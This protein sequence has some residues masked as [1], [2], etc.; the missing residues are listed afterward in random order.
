MSHR[1]LI[2]DHTINKPSWGQLYG[3]SLSL[4]L[5]E[6][7]LQTPGIKLCITPDNWYAKQLIEDLQFFLKDH[8][9][10]QEILVFPDWETL[11]YDQFSPHQDIISERL[12]ALSRLPQLKT[13]IVISSVST[14]MH[15]IAP[16]DFV[17]QHSLLLECHQQLNLDT[18]R[19]QLIQA[20]YHA[21]NTVLEH[22]EFALRGAILDLFPMGSSI[23]YRI[24]LFD[25]EIASLRSF[26]PES[27]RTIDKIEKIHILPAREMLFNE[28]GIN[29]FRQAFRNEFSGNPSQ[30]P[31]YEAVS[32][33]Q[34]PAGIEYYLPLFFSKAVSF[35]DYLPPEST[36]TMIGSTLDYAEQFWQELNQRFTQR[37][38]DRNRPILAPERC[39][40]SPNE[41]LAATKHYTRIK[42]S[43]EPLTEKKSTHN[44]AVN[45]P[46]LFTIDRHS[47][48]PFH[49]FKTWL[50]TTQQRAI[51]VVESL[52]RRE[53]ILDLLKQSGITPKWQPSW[54]ACIEDNAPI[55]ITLGT[56]SDGAELQHLSI[57]VE[58]QLF[59]QQATPQQRKITKSIDPDV[60]IRDLAE[61]RIGAPVVHLEF[62]VGRYQGLQTFVH[63]GLSNEFLCLSYAGDDKIYVP[64]TSLHLISRYTGADSDHAPLHRLGSD[65]WQKEKKKAAEKIH[66]V[67]IELLEIYAK[68]AQAPGHQ[69][70]LHQLDYQRFAAGFPFTLTNDQESAITQIIQDMQSPHPMDRLICGDVGFGKTEVAMRAAFIAA[71]DGQQICVLCPTTLLADQHFATFR[72]RF[73]DFPITIELLSRFRSEKQAEKVVQGLANG[74]IDIVIGTHKLLQKSIQFKQ[75]GLLI[76]DEEHRFGVKQKEYIKSLRAQIDL[77]CMTAT[78]IPRTLNM[79]MA[80]IRDISL[81]ATPPA[82]RLAIKTFWQEHSDSIV[83]EAILRE[84]LRGG[85][86]FF[87][88]NNVQ[89]I[90]RI[91]QELQKLVPQA[92]V[93][94]AHGQ[95]RERELERIMSDFYH[96]QFNVLV[97]TTIIETGIDI[98]TANTIIIDR[99]DK[100]GLAQLHQLRGRVG[101]SHH[102]AYAYLLTPS[103]KLLSADAIKRLEAI[104]SLEDLGAGF[105]LASHDL[106][107]RGAGELLGEE[108]SG[109]MHAIGFDLF[110]EMLER[111]VKDLKSGKTPELNAPLKEG[112]DIDL[113]ISTVI[114]DTYI[115][116]VHLRLIFYKRIAHAQSEPALHDLQIELIDRFGLLPPTVKYL[117]LITKLKYLAT[118]LGIQ[119]I[120]VSEQKGK[121]EFAAE[122]NI[123]PATVIKLI[124][125]QS[126]RYQLQGP[127]RFCFSLDSKQ[128]EDKIQEI[129]ALLKM[130]T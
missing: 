97:C 93:R 102:Q 99:A 49:A 7:Y 48:E 121:L 77:L 103:P 129:S 16:P 87:L 51:L 27:Q 36:I 47:A 124:Q 57:I 56:L 35:F 29:Q 46:P 76:I 15:R 114:P 50:E 118:K 122:P 39:F 21:V 63:D 43:H 64:V 12:T 53:I 108:Q 78:P 54:Q 31:L 6:Y 37:S 125:T 127:S 106:E 119:K 13:A 25:D 117:F 100:F 30:V 38:H 84:I 32:A 105:T 69:Y 72:D 4:A 113:R 17:Q 83:S 101:R 67:A 107:I 75:L 74:Q 96:H 26:N 110:M 89:T 19:E 23:P 104:V 62:G 88:H 112:P 20:G 66:D 120:Q 10:P 116:D 11:P 73:A 98:P 40:L 44:F 8:P 95:M 128:P 94:N 1:I 5:A 58:T 9:N 34:I 18:F 82:K 111:A 91:T 85:Q 65:L 71:Q 123:N 92:K 115:G 24:E 45:P 109:N 22:G 79:S 60:I 86:V 126:Q 80:G 14:L 61:L 2:Q 42:L 70:Q 52:G 59:G 130:L 90:E 3:S 41:L 33:G 68:R 81:I 55:T 28:Q